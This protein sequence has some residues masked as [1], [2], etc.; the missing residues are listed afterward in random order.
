MFSTKSLQ[1]TGLYAFKSVIVKITFVDG[2]FAFLFVVEYAPKTPE[3]ILNGIFL[4]LIVLCVQ[5]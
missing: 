2:F 1:I 4:T 3:T 5:M